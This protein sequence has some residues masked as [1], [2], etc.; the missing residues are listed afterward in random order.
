MPP[1]NCATQ[2]LTA[3]CR[4]MR[5]ASSM[6]SVTAGFTWQPEIGPMAYASASITKP[7]VS[8]MPS[9]P[10]YSAASTAAPT[11]KKTSSSVPRNSAASGWGLSSRALSCPG[12]AGA[13]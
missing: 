10:I 4:S 2:Y 8:A 9:V 7:K 12:S 3:V 11:P 1:T 6:P 13:T 5:P